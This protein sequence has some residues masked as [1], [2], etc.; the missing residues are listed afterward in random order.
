MKKFLS[1]IVFITLLCSINLPL[2]AAD[3]QNVDVNIRKIE[4]AKGSGATRDDALI[5]AKADA[6]MQCVKTLVQSDEEKAKFE[7]HKDTILCTNAD[8]YISADTVDVLDKV[9]TSSGIRIEIKVVVNIG[10][11]EAD[12][13]SLG[14]IKT[15]SQLTQDVGDIKILA[16]FDFR[17]TGQRPD[18]NT[19]WAIDRANWFMGAKKMDYIMQD[20][21]LK[22]AADDEVIKS[23]KKGAN[24]VQSIADKAQADIYLK[25]KASF[26]KT[27]GDYAQAKVQIE[28]YET[29]SN[30]LIARENAQSREL[31][32]ESGQDTSMKAAIEEAMGGVMDGLMQKMTKFWKDS[33]AKGKDYAVVLNYSSEDK[34]DAFETAL[35]GM[36]ASLKMKGQS[37]S[38]VEYSIKYKGRLRDLNKALKGKVNGL[39]RKSQQFNKIEFAI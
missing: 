9:K 17:S 3:V 34:K 16:F 21:A 29:G 37:G 39:S 27:S 38:S 22:L 2:Y 12:L 33:I 5:K 24:Y 15:A 35:K 7:K 25:I 23:V 18:K 32:A 36:S 26:D 11:L 14:V 6:I 10:V 4:S 31:S 20:E 8:K 19:G 13:A 28:A 1:L 30:S